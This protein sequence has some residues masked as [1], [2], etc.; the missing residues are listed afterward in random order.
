MCAAFWGRFPALLL[1]SLSTRVAVLLLGFR[2]EKQM[3]RHQYFQRYGLVVMS[4]QMVMYW[5]GRG[6]GC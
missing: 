1:C 2:E 6:S 4:E 3:S 5:V